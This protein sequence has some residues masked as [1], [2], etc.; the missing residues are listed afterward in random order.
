MTL[1]DP[2]FPP[3][4]NPVGTV[5]AARARSRPTSGSCRTSSDP[6]GSADAPVRGVDTQVVNMDRATAERAFGSDRGH[7]R[8]GARAR[9]RT[10]RLPGSQPDWPADVSGSPGPSP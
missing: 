5:A 2:R 3:A 6:D 1:H 10:T 9:S 4:P 7:L 8:N